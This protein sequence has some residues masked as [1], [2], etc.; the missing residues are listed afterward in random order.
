[1]VNNTYIYRRRRAFI[2]YFFIGS[3]NWIFLHQTLPL[4]R[5]LVVG[6]KK[7]LC[8]F[9]LPVQMWFNQVLARPGRG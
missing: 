7:H 3:F 6:R 9:G 2:F 4:T 1:M 8:F 5:W